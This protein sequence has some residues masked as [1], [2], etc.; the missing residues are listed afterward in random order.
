[1][2]TCKKYTEL[3]ARNE[4]EQQV[5]ADLISA[6][7]KRG[8]KVKHHGTGATHAPSTAPAD[9]TVDWGA[10]AK[11][12][13]LLVEVA[14]RTDESEFT[15]ITEHLNRAVAAAGNKTI[16]CLY[17][18]RSTS[19]RFAKFIR[20]E[21][22]RREAN[23]E[24]GRIIFVRLNDLQEI[25]RRW[26][27]YPKSAYPVDAFHAAF[28]RWHEFSSDALAYKVLQSEIFPDWVEKENELDAELQKG[29]ALKQA[30]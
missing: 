26:A 28:A 1:M 29:V 25:L 6:L 13:R 7:E 22:Q 3:D 11:A 27:S 19:V 5:T 9:I 14:Q 15:S 10:G 4:L 8:A 2:A 24:P 12:T 23:S 21:N 20:N 16:H 30:G 18:G 17:S